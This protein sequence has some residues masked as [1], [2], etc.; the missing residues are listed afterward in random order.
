M[1]TH[2]VMFQFDNAANAEEAQRRLLAM[3]GQ[4]PELQHIEAGLD[5]LRSDRSMDLC[6]ITRFDDMAAMERYQVHPVHQE[7]VGFIK[8]CATKVVAVDYEG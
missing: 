5:V 1:L 7:V 4:I 6:L 3:D 2:V 8:T